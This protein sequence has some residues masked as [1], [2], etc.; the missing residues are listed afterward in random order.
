MGGGVLYPVEEVS[1]D[2]DEKTRR[3]KRKKKGAC[4]D[5]AGSAGG[6]MGRAAAGKHPI[7]CSTRRNAMMDVERR[8]GR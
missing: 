1:P 3:K 8:D 5:V 7:R 4:L 2:E 6:S